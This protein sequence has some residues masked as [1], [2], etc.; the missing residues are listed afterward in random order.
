MLSLLRRREQE[1]VSYI[2]PE[3]P[4]MPRASVR[5]R[6]RTG[7]AGVWDVAGGLAR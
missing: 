1:Q 4:A 2:D 3:D 6:G 5:D 7:A